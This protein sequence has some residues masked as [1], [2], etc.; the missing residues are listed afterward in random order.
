MDPCLNSTFV[1]HCWA[2]AG[3][4][5]RAAGLWVRREEKTFSKPLLHILKLSNNIFLK[6]LSSEVFHDRNVSH[7]IEATDCLLRA[8]PGGGGVEEREAPLRQR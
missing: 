1:L 2:T 4:L 8:T 5:L 3:K 6:L 7:L